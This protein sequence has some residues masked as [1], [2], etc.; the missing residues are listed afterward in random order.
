MELTKKEQH[1]IDTYKLEMGDISKIR[2]ISEKLGTNKYSV[3]IAKEARKNPELLEDYQGMSSVIDWATANKA[4]IFRFSFEEAKKE[5]E[6]WHE[7]LINNPVISEKIKNKEIDEDRI[8][9]R[10]SDNKYFFYLLNEYDLSVEG[11]QMMHCVGGAN[12]KQKVRN[13]AENKGGSFIVSLRDE[14]NRP[15]VTIEIN[16]NTGN[17]IQIRG[18][19]NSNLSSKL[20]KKI[21]EFALFASGYQNIKDKEILDLINMNLTHFNQ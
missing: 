10:C 14:Q 20:K 17:E 18:K 8:I 9:F 11:N 13:A 4:D 16:S 21:I 3:W 5:E 12:Y 19:G 15:H 2:G 6:N 1:I 7:S